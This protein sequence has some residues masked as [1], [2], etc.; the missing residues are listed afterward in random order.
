MT[1]SLRDLKVYTTYPHRCSYLASEEA[2]TLFIDPRQTV[3]QTLYSNLSLLGFR[4]SGNHIYRPHC[5]HCNACIPARVVVPEFRPSRGQRRCLKRNNDLEVIP[6][7]SIATDAC[8]GLY[9]RYIAS[10]HADGD[11]YPPDRDQYE[12]FLNNPW[13]VT[14]YYGFNAGGRILAVSVVDEM[15]DGL[16]AIYTFYEPD[17]EARSLGRYAILWQIDRC[18]EL[19]LPYVYLGY[20]IRNCRKMN[21]KVDY[22]PLETM[23]NNQWQRY[24]EDL[25]QA[26]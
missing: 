11:M 23:V 25:L 5:S 6:L 21:Y 18:R 19:E 10:R 24:S 14:R 20:W 16:S 2:T 9:E 12:T 26:L 1:S 22:Q 15:L 13:G 3:D 8:Y 17:A 7:E 4:R